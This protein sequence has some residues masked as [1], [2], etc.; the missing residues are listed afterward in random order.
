MVPLKRWIGT[1][2]SIENRVLNKGEL[3]I[4]F[5]IDSFFFNCFSSLKVIV[6][7]FIP[8]KGPSFITFFYV[9]N[10]IWEESIIVR[11]AFVFCFFLKRTHPRKWGK[12]DFWGNDAK[13]RIPYANVKHYGERNRFSGQ[14]I[15]NRELVG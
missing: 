2:S 3:S 11:P 7:K 4:L 13:K 1:S 12:W 10:D 5:L 8:S 6:F 14:N 15:F 9:F